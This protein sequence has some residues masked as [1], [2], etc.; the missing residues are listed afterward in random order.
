VAGSDYTSG[1]GG[2]R[3]DYAD[4]TWAAGQAVQVDAVN[5]YWQIT[6]VQ[7]EAGTTATEYEH[8]TFADELAEC[9]RYLVVYS[10]AGRFGL[11]Q[12]YSA[13]LADVIVPYRRKMRAAPT[14]V[15]SAATDFSV[16][17]ATGGSLTLTALSTTS[18]TSRNITVRTTV[19]SGQVAGY[20]IQLVNVNADAKLTISA[21]L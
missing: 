11:G 8:R 17:N 4:E 12:A 13:T 21:E 20:A 6:G 19:S 16:V 18:A 2:S 14:L 1:S 5:D 9:E 15:I 7:L 10:G 3:G